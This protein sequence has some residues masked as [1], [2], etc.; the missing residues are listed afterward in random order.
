VTRLLAA[1]LAHLFARE[2]VKCPR[3]NKS[4]LDARIHRA[5]LVRASGEW[6]KLAR[7]T[8]NERCEGQTWRDANPFPLSK[9]D[10]P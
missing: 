6:A 9:N 10:L 1:Q 7:I 3:Q 4:D 5:H 2:S 8:W